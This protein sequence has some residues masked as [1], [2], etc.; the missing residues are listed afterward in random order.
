MVERVYLQDPYKQGL[1]AKVVAV[2]GNR[3]EF[4]K[5]LFHGE[6]RAYGHPQ[7]GDRGHFFHGGSKTWVQRVVDR[8]NRVLHFVDG[9]APEVG[10][11]A[12]LHLDWDRRFPIMRA[13]TALHLFLKALTEARAGEVVAPPEVVA[14]GQVKLVVRFKAYSPPV[15]AGLVGAVRERI[16]ENRPVT[17]RYAAREDAERASDP[18]AFLDGSAPGEPT[19][20]LVEVEGVCRYPCDGLHVRRTGEVGEGFSVGDV[21][22]RREGHRLMLRVPRK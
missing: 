6:S 13:H 4:D 12:R 19:L 11:E 2:A 16:K 1:F 8:E 3:V 15:L 7:A 17:T 10:A 22:P 14:G 18:Q 5:T 21:L 9:V 20:R